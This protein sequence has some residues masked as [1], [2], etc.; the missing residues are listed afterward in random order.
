MIG[1]QAKKKNTNKTIRIVGCFV[2]I[3]DAKPVGALVNVLFQVVQVAWYVIFL[4]WSGAKKVLYPR[5][6][7]LFGSAIQKL[8]AIILDLARFHESWEDFK[9]HTG[10]SGEI[11]RG[12]TGRNGLS[13]LNVALCYWNLLVMDWP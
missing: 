5:R 8:E 4:F 12:E 11:W 7:V 3:N 9:T 1:G 13:D 6:D 10:N 2:F